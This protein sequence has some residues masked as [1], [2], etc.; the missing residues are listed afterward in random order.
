MEL[1]TKYSEGYKHYN[2]AIAKYLN[3]KPRSFLKHC[4]DGIK[5]AV[6]IQQE[7]IKEVASGKEDGHF[8]VRSQSSD[9]RYRLSFGAGD[10]IPRCNCPDFCH[11]GLLCKHCFA[12]FNHYPK[13][14][15]ESLSEKCRENPHLSLNKKHVFADPNRYKVSDE[16]IKEGDEAINEYLPIS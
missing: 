16:P 15:W 8:Q 7:H 13:W 1:N 10:N 6:D 11:T 9:I 5:F 4:Q 14:Q 3:N 2:Q 12:L